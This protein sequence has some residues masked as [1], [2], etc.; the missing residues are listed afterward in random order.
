MSK[1][2]SEKFG[3]KPAPTTDLEMRV[4]CQRPGRID[5]EGKPIYF[6]EQAHKDTCDVNKI[7]QKYDRQGLINHVSHFEAQF[8]DVSGFDFKTM[9]E[10]VLNA[11]SM[12]DK[13]PSAIRTRFNNDPQ[14]LLTFMDD[15]NNRDEAIKLGL[16]NSQW[17]PETDGLGEHVKLGENK[18][19]ADPA[20]E[21]AE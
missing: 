7:I 8:G 5:G 1:F 10:K 3:L 9:Q 20:A 11:K 4:F 12:F 6:T 17:T 18:V 15:P 13:L 14:Y 16:I 2:Y 19:K 21:P